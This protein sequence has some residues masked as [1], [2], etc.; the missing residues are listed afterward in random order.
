ML[1]HSYFSFVNGYIQ[2]KKYSLQY[3]KND[4]SYISTLILRMKKCISVDTSIFYVC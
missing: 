2:K 4:I 1:F 3:I